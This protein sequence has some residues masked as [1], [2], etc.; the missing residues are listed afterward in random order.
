MP[1]Q[2][3]TPCSDSS[4]PSEDRQDSQPDNTVSGTGDFLNQ[5]GLP[6]TEVTGPPRQIPYIDRAQLQDEGSSGSPIPDGPEKASTYDPGTKNNRAHPTA[7]AKVPAPP[8]LGNFVCSRCSKEFRHHWEIRQGTSFRGDMNPLI[9]ELESTKKPTSGL[10]RVAIQAAVEHSLTRKTASDMPSASTDQDISFAVS[11]D[12]QRR[13]MALPEKT[14][15]NG[16]TRSITGLRAAG[17][18]RVHFRSEHYIAVLSTGWWST[19]KRWCKLF[20]L[21]FELGH[22]QFGR[23][24]GHTLQ[25]PIHKVS[26]IGWFR[27]HR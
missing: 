2:S 6:S 8:F 13:H 18:T 9:P 12:A 17:W 22:Q 4:F 5:P 7:Q 20:R 26:F 10:S 24:P 27:L 16:T 23:P 1:S 25:H 14:I 3:F 21:L 11:M 19:H 15:S